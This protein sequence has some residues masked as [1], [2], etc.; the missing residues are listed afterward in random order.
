MGNLAIAF[1][2]KT[3]AER[4]KIAKQFYKNF[5]D[6]LLETVKL[7][8]ISGSEFDKRCT[9]DFTEINLMAS[10][11]KNI[12]MHCGHQMNWEYGNWRMAKGSPIP[13]VGIYKKL[14]NAAINKIFYD[15]RS[16]SGTVLVSTTEFKNGAQTGAIVQYSLGLAADQNGNPYRCYWLNF[17]N[18]P[19]PFL[20]GPAIGAIRNNTAVIFSH[21]IKTKRGHYHFATKLMAE[22]A[23]DFT[24]E[25]LT[26]Q[27]R[28]LL[29]AAIRE[30]PDNYLWS[31]RRWRHNYGP[32]HKK[33]WIDIEPPVN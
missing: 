3:E 2:E 27:Y 21:F 33:R 20:K 8:S 28:N 7:I 1:P 18:K 5:I 17:F 26:L 29:E 16:R 25:E 30:T 32:D 13:F 24:A 23:V 9:M 22:N 11:G 19:V 31:H 12:Q 15:L 10:K 4:L 14:S 6:T